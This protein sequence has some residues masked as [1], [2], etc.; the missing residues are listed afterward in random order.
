[1]PDSIAQREPELELLPSAYAPYRDPRDYILSWT[2]AIWV[3][4]GLGRLRDHYDRDVRVHTAYGETYDYRHVMENSLQK[5]AAFPNGGG[6]FGEDVIWEQRGPNGFISSH[7]VF[8]NGT[9]TGFWTYGPPTGRDWTSRT[10]AHCLVRDNKVVEE[11]IVRDEY[12]VLTD[13]GLDPYLIARELARRSPVTGDAVG[14]G[15]PAFAGRIGDASREGVSGPRPDRHR[16]ECALVQEYFEEVWNGRMFNL[17]PQYCSTQ[18][19][20]QTVRMR[21]VQGVDPYQIELINLLAT[22]PD[23]QVE[24]RDIAVNESPDL[25]VRVAVIWQLRGTYS[26]VPTYGPV[27]R[28]PVV[29][30]GATHAEIRDGRIL[31]EW[32][33]FDEVAVIA[34]IEAARMA[35]A[36]G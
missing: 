16:A 34:Q 21:R 9:H 10:V 28:S 25:G 8:K 17:V 7:R 2:D 4:R 14:G 1:M 36:G 33:V 3:D 11:W 23:G 30:L 32:R 24:I 20:C 35:Q 15:G 5:F 27:T 18:V 13:L 19:V 26:G 29:V 6:G 22:I 31:R 12:A